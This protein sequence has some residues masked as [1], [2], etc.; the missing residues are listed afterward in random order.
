[1]TNIPQWP[2]RFALEDLGEQSETAIP[3]KHDV[4]TA[5]SAAKIDAVKT[6]TALVVRTA[7]IETAL[8]D[9]QAALRWRK[10]NGWSRANLALKTGFSASQIQDYEQGSRRGKQGS[11]AEISADAWRRYRLACAAVQADLPMPW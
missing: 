3:P 11:K 10:A 2:F 9:G 7:P 6:E 1:M 4:R 5:L 8:Q